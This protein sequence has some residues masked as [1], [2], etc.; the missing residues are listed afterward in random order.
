[1]NKSALFWLM[2]VT[3]V[4]CMHIVSILQSYVAAG[5]GVLGILAELGMPWSLAIVCN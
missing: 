4:V 1:M 2:L 5:L 3:L